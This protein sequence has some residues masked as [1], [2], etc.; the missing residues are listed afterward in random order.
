MWRS[1]LMKD[2]R[3]VFPHVHHAVP[4]LCFL[5]EDHLKASSECHLLCFSLKRGTHYTAL[6]NQLLSC[7]YG[8]LTISTDWLTLY[9]STVELF[10]HLISYNASTWSYT[11]LY[12]I[13]IILKVLC[14]NHDV[15]CAIIRQSS[16]SGTAFALRHPLY[17]KCCIRFIF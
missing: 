14:H 11:L 4:W 8:Q 10:F 16:N 3:H 2:V 12:S 5:S 17:N 6:Y 15:L 13:T 9:Y 7:F 1:R